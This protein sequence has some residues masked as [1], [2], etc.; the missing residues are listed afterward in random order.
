MHSAGN[1]DFVTL[2]WTTNQKYYQA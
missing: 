1:V 2:T